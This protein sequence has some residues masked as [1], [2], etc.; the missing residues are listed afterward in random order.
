VDFLFGQYW[1]L[2]GFQPYYQPNT[3][4]IQGVAG[5][6]YARTPQ[7]R[8]SKT[9]KAYPVTFEIAV[10]AVRPVQR[11]S[12]TPDG[13]AGLRLALDSVTALQTVGSTGTQISSLSIAG[14]GL[15]R[16]VAVNNFSPTGASVG[17]TTTDL[18]MGGA[19]VEAFIPVYPATKDNKFTSFSLNGEFE[20]G[21]GTADQYTGLTGG[22]AFPTPTKGTFTPDIDP[23]IVTY[24]YAGKLHGI[25]WTSYLF[26]AQWYLPATDGK[27]WISGNYSH[28]NSVNMH[29]YG[30]GTIGSPS[31]L[32]G[33]E[34]F[35]D[36]N[37][38]F[39]PVPAAR[40]GLE[41]A[42]TRTTYVDGI[43][44]TNLRAQLSAFFIY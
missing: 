25:Q 12:G 26:G 28:M 1:Q 10:A 32:M 15:I 9:V 2:F 37:F 30:V 43:H 23:G 44:A 36:V 14:T 42:N 29:Y 8:V 20:S 19:T 27:A 7:I 24:D 13:E 5:E 35:Y 4:E 38:F 40:I 33:S 39:D 31:S 16:H 3:V 34:D 6:V 17:D 18:T 22:V 21:Y 11:D 41:Y